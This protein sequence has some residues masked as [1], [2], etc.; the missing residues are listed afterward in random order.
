MAKLQLM[1]VF[2]LHLS[3]RV[4]I[5]LEISLLFF[6]CN[7]FYAFNLI[8][9]KIDL[10]NNDCVITNQDAGLHFSRRFSRQF[11][12]LFL[13]NFSIVCYHFMCYFN[14]IGTEMAVELAIKKVFGRHLNSHLGCSFCI[15]SVFLQFIFCL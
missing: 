2:G 3:R 6:L 7:F 1:N 12:I 14:Q 9:S 11:R 4:D 10:Q 13:Q 5:H 15:Y 8:S